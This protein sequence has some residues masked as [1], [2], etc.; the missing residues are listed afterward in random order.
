MKISSATECVSAVQDHPRSLILA[1]ME[2][3]YAT[4]Y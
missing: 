3:A 2:R 1:P 4:S